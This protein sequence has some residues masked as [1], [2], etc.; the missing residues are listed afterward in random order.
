MSDEEKIQSM[1]NTIGEPTD[2]EQRM[3]VK[4]AKS[5]CQP[6]THT[7]QVDDTDGKKWKCVPKGKFGD[8]SG[9][10]L[11]DFPVTGD[12][13]NGLKVGIPFM[14]E[15]C[16]SRLG[17]RIERNPKDWSAASFNCGRQYNLTTAEGM[18]DE[19]AN[20]TYFPAYAGLGENAP[21]M[22]YETAKSMC[23][24]DHAIFGRWK[25][26]DPVAFRCM[27]PWPEQPES[28]KLSDTFW[29]GDSFKENSGARV[30]IQQ[31][32]TP[33]GKTLALGEGNRL[34]NSGDLQKYSI[35]TKKNDFDEMNKVPEELYYNGGMFKA[36]GA[37]AGMRGMAYRKC[38][39][40]DND[41]LRCLPSED[42]LAAKPDSH[43]FY[44]YMRENNDMSNTY[45]GN[46]GYD[47]VPN[48]SDTCRYCTKIVNPQPT[49]EPYTRW[50]R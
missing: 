16:G 34:L 10:A 19:K 43:H 8:R 12:R 3:L 9:K 42:I 45:C 4:Y 24:D 38:D 1:Y 36:C 18:T 25:K 40:R 13:M 7:A 14:D 6:D 28:Q 47:Y 33:D 44:T 20:N 26:G 32:T 15:Y 22:T 30:P 49:K 48:S 37:H 39:E 23:R 27:T 17:Y 41:F 21:V 11:T 31:T 2:I 46:K 35:I 5:F 29:V 50:Y